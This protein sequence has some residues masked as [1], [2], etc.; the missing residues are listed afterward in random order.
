MSIGTA[1]SGRPVS[2]AECERLWAAWTPA[3][4]ARRL[5]AVRVPWYVAGGWALDLFAGGLDRTHSDLEI[6]VPSSG[7]DEIAAALPGF[8]WDVVGDGR[9]RPYPAASDEHHQTWLRDPASGRYHLDVF[10]EP[11]IGDRWVCRRDPS[12]T[13]P[14]DELILRTTDGIPYSVPEAALLFKAKS[15]RDKDEADFQRVLPAM[16]SDRRSRLATW[17]TLIHPGHPWIDRLS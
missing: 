13:L 12:L 4:V 17:L 16:T 9:I 10:R 11:H 3:E 14:F 1:D 5:S 15:V 8:E 7:F 6:G 2:A